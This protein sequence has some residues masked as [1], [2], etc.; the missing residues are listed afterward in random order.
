[1]ASTDCEP[2]YF[3]GEVSS[4]DIVAQE[5]IPRFG[6]VSAHFEELHQIVL[7]DQLEPSRIVSFMTDVLTMYITA[8]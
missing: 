8:D 1:M 4:V 2:A 7:H 3:N 5:Q 6:G